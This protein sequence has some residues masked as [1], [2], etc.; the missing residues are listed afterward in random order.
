M[1]CPSDIRFSVVIPTYNRLQLVQRAIQSVI[2]QTI[3]PEEIIVVDDGSTDKTSALLKKNYPLIKVITQDNRGVSY[4]R[5]RGAEIASGNW[6]AFLDSDDTWHPEKLEEQ[7]N[8]LK[9]RDDL[10]LCHT[11]EIWIRNGKEVKQP[12]YLN[13]TDSEIFSN[14][15]T[16]C[17]ICP[18]SVVIKKS[19]FFKLGKFREDLAVCEDYDLW[20]KLLINYKAGYLP[21][22]LVTK[23]GGHIDQLSTRH[24]GMDRFRVNSLEQILETQSL[25]DKIRIDILRTIIDKLDLLS[26]GFSKRKKFIEA[27]QFISKIKKFESQLNTYSTGE[28]VRI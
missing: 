11:D 8:F 6:L 26:I 22:K 21:S 13:K 17:I 10:S 25:T 5:N 3:S 19:I 28:K 12:T 27:E 9:E 7:S 4:S 24:W 18:S 20:L 16:R 23:Y 2:N 1:P 15:L 14:S